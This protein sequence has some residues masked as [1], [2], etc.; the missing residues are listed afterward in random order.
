MIF[1]QLTF[2][3]FGPYRG[4]QTLNLSPDAARPIILLGGLNG[5][6]KTTLLDAIRLALYGHRAQ[7]SNRGNLGYGEFLSQC[8]N[9]HTGI[10]EPASVELIFEQLVNDTLTEF[11]IRRAWTQTLKSGRDSLEV[12]VDGADDLTLTKTWDEYI[13]DLL[14]LGISNLFLFDGEQVMELA[15]QDTPPPTVVDAIRTLLGLELPERLSLDLEVLVNRKRKALANIEELVDLENIEQQLNHHQEEHAAAKQDLAQIQSKLDQAIALSEAA[16]EKFISEGGR[17][18]GE[19]SQLEAQLQR[20]QAE[21]AAERQALIVLA[22][23]ALPLAFIRPLLSQ[24]QAQAQTEALDQSAKIARNLLREHDQRLLDFIVQLPIASDQL[25]QIQTFLQKEAQALSKEI[26]PDAPW[27]QADPEASETLDKL[28]DYQLSAQVQQ[29]KKHLTKLKDLEAEIATT[30]RHLAAAPSPEVYE[31]L[32]DAVRQAQTKVSKLKTEHERAWLRVNAAAQALETAKKALT[33][34]GEQT[35]DH[36]NNEYF[37]AA[38]AR[39]Q[40]TLRLFQEQLK[41]R[42]LNQLEL[43]VT[44]FFLYL[45]H[46]SNLVNRVEIDAQTFGLLLYDAQGKPVPKHRLSAGEKQLLA[47]AS[48]W[49][50]AA[51]SGRNLP[52][53]I[54]TPLGRLDSSHR[55]NLVERY[56]PAASHQV[57]LLST[58][59]EVGK[60]ELVCLRQ[61]D[62][63]SREYLLQYDPAERQ[64]VVK[65]GYF[66]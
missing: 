63:I 10:N 33:Q 59:T 8:I 31:K 48:L 36:Q 23:E 11:Q 18:A 16:S 27:L 35:I 12:L 5:G 24:V 28:L 7:C 6:G 4:R 46:K 30:E 37:L 50:L 64:T 56:F 13:E 39:V 47:I 17:I 53:A 15:E 22:A 49:G 19:R 58:D 14:P 34:Y 44:E 43:V 57:I 32:A 65:P 51:V 45:L 26:L 3:N 61:K 25:A 21:T 2:Q 62:V 38:A 55:T 66:W 54:D 29:A 41:Q 42:K 40:S 60:T 1:R 20:L 52:V 9:R